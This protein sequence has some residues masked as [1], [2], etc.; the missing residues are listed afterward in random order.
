MDG[1]QKF[2]K[3]YNFIFSQ[4]LLDFRAF[5][6]D[7]PAFLAAHESS[8][9][10]V[11]EYGCG[12]GEASLRCATEFPR[13]EVTGVVVHNA[14]NDVAMRRSLHIGHEIPDPS[15]LSFT[16]LSAR[17]STLAIAEVENSEI[18]LDALGEDRYDL[19]FS[20]CVFEHVSRSMLGDTLAAILR[21]LKTTGFFYLKINPLF[22]S[23]R[24]SHLSGVLPEPW[25]HLRYDHLS[26]KKMFMSSSDL[27]PSATEK[28]WHQYESLNEITAN[29]LVSLI[30]QAGFEVIHE[31]RKLE[32]KPDETLLSAFTLDALRTK[33]ITLIARKKF[34]GTKNYKGNLLNG[35]HGK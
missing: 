2:L 20:W 16:N 26:L 10:R 30:V 31:E 24:G 25:V 22:F 5:G 21:S 23:P 12:T 34:P 15:N 11:L 32:G 8:Q 4:I 18:N 27:S 3:K 35:S 17:E 1:Q 19:V 28:I 6:V 9:A 7:I 14:S 33:E 29:S 13:A